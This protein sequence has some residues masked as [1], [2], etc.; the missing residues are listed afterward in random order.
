MHTPKC[1]KTKIEKFLFYLNRQVSILDSRETKATGN[2]KDQV[3]TFF[4]SFG[5][6]KTSK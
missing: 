1:F 6:I 4:I 5:N 3:N 2:I